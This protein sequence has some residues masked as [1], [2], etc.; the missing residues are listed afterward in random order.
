MTETKN[1][2]YKRGYREGFLDGFHAARDNPSLMSPNIPIPRAIP[3]TSFDKSCSMC[4]KPFVDSMGRLITYAV[5]CG[6]VGCPRFGTTSINVSNNGGGG[7][8][9]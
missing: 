6:Y 9:K 8:N 4:G 3:A 5:V 1:D 2:D 7:P